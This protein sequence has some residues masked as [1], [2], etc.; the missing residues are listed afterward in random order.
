MHRRRV[1]LVTAALLVAGSLTL[2]TSAPGA[3]AGPTVGV[4]DSDTVVRPVTTPGGLTTSA[5]LVAAQGEYESFQLVVTGPATD[6]SVSGDLFGWGTT[7]LYREAYYTATQRSDMEGATGRWPDALIPATDLFYGETRNAFPIDVPTGENRVVWVDVFVPPGTTAGSY[8]GDLTVSSADGQ[9]QVPVG[10]EVLNWTMPATS[11]LDN[12]FMV[13]T[14][15]GGGNAICLAHTGSKTCNGDKHLRAQLNGMYARLGLEDRMTTGNGFG[16]NYDTTSADYAAQDW[17]NQLEGPAIRGLD[18]PTAGERLHLDGAQ[19]THVAAYT[20]ADFHCLATCA[21]QW[22]AEA[23]EPGQDWS[24]K[25]LWYGCDEAGS[26]TAAWQTCNDNLQQAQSGW[27]RTA[28]VESTLSQYQSYAP[29]GM[30]ATVI[31]TY[32]DQMQPYQAASIR[33]SYD[34]WLAADPARAVW[35]ATACNAFGCDNADTTAEMYRGL[36]GY[37]IDAPANASRAMPWMIYRERATGELNWSTTKRL[38][39]AWQ[40][41]GLWESGGNGDGTMFYPGTVARIGGTHDIPLESLRLKRLRDGRE[42]WEYLTWLTQQGYGSQVRDIVDGVYPD[43]RSAVI[44]RDGSGAGSLLAARSALVDLV[45]A[46]TPSTSE[47]GRIIFSSDRDGDSEIYSMAP[48]GTDVRPMTSNGVPDEFPAFS[49]DSGQVAWTHDGA[50]WVMDADG[51]GAHLVRGGDGV[52]AEKPAWTPTG[53]LVYVQHV[54]AGPTELWQVGTDGSNAHAVVSAPGLNVYDPDVDAAGNLYYTQDWPADAGGGAHIWRKDAGQAPF[55]LSYGPLDEAVAV[56]PDAASISFSRVGIGWTGQYDVMLKG[57]SGEPSTTN[58]TQDAVGG[59]T[60]DDFQSVFSPS[61]QA[62]ALSSTA[63]GD[64]DIWR[65]GTDGT[66]VVR[67]TDDPGRDVDPD[68]GLP[69]AL[70]PVVTPSSCR[71]LPVT[72][73][74]ARGGVPTSGRD[75][76]R[77]TAGPDVIKALAGADVV[78]GRGG[79]DTIQGGRGGD[80]LDGGHGRDAC[81]GGT[82]KDAARACERTTGVP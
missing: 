22:E 36:P 75:V 38:A 41:G 34:G 60:A 7:D 67:L 52:V 13:Q 73:D 14:E 10:L 32:V 19:P 31:A 44:G 1:H 64:P 15:D 79:A 18:G 16:T 50:I 53:D 12:V 35:L 30:G 37:A 49:P 6:V 58:V 65:V 55:E 17:E 33:S 5:S 23:T 71:G 40:D 20:Y 82:G 39:T 63:G 28:L 11:S 80:F 54:A 24:S 74:L 69:S 76:I 72:V 4:A 27:H 42:D 29:A 78:C 66:G 9:T 3:A 51:S 2:L 48:N 26:S 59:G 25:M 68:W 8:Q 46:A 47:G 45:R 62:L 61:G 57:N 70:P 77:G 43:M 81:A 21:N 56:S